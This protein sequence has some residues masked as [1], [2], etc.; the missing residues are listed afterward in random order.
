MPEVPGYSLVPQPLCPPRIAHELDWDRNWAAA[1]T[2][3]TPK[4]IPV[5]LKISVRTSQRVTVFL[6]SQANR[7]MLVRKNWCFS[8]ERGT[9]CVDWLDRC[10]LLTFYSRLV[11]LRTAMFNIQEIVHCHLKE[12]V[13]FVWIWEQTAIIS[14]YSINWLV[15]I[16][17]RKQLKINHTPQLA[18][19]CPQLHKLTYVPL[20]TEFHFNTFWND[21][22]IHK[23]SWIFYFIN[24]T[25]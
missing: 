3:H 24:F 7:L 15:C 22:Y 10:F 21:T 4:F 18:T 12:F 14:L 20:Y 5:L 25:T 11:T 8:S 9:N 16:F 13:C 17:G 1:V 23:S 19:C 6:L 2:A